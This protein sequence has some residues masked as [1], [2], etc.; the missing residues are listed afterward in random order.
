MQRRMADTRAKQIV[1]EA[2]RQA[3]DLKRDKVLEG[4]EEALKD[5]LGCGETSI[6]ENV[7][8]AVG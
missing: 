5:Y 2:E 8:T 1:A 7:E 4:R 6:S 3:E